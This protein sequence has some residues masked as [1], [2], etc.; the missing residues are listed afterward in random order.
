MRLQL[1]DAEHV[2]GLVGMVWHYVFALLDREIDMSAESAGK[3]A[4]DAEAAVRSVLEAC[5]G[6]EDDPPPVCC[7]ACGAALDPSELNNGPMRG[8]RELGCAPWPMCEGCAED[9][10]D[11]TCSAIEDDRENGQNEAAEYEG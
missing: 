11:A 9:S 2:D 7:S 1:G 4:A 8:L 6:V 10:L 3:A 5:W